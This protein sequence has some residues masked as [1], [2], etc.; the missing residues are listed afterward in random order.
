MRN[1]RI[2][3][4]AIGTLKDGTGSAGT[5]GQV[6]SSTATATAW[7]TPLA[8]NAYT[9][10]F[11][12]SNLTLNVLTITHNLGTLYPQVCI[13]D[14][15]GA[16][17]LPESVVVTSSTVVTVALGAGFGAITGTWKAGV[18]ASGG[19]VV[20]ASSGATQ[21]TMYLATANSTAVQCGGNGAVNWGYNGTIFLPEEASAITTG[22]KLT[23][24][25]TNALSG[26]YILA[27]Y[28]YVAGGPYTLMFSTG[29][30]AIPAA[31]YI[32]TNVTNVV[33][34][35][36]RP[37]TYYYM[38]IFNNANA[39]TTLGIASGS[40]IA[41]KPFRNISQA[42][43]LGSLAAAPSTITEQATEATLGHLYMRVII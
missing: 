25:F 5:S 2:E 19:T 26:S 14:N 34:G 23:T 27:C 20:S 8:G 30:N 15:N 29:V 39:V 36:L 16:Q 18:N 10:T 17:I 6:L 3:L 1:G 11:D 37:D 35:S 41:F 31:G 42:N 9:R 28:K 43:A 13:Y 33:D 12:S 22:S 38:V 21:G 4:N 40:A 24:A 32:T 7:I